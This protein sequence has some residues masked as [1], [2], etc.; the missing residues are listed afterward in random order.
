MWKS[1]I[2]RKVAADFGFIIPFIE[3]TG[4]AGDRRSWTSADFAPSQAQ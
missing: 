1:F 4:Y 2:A 3:V